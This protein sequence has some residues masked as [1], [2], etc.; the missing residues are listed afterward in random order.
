MQKMQAVR[1]WKWF[2]QC[3]EVNRQTMHLTIH[4]L[5][6]QVR[7]SDINLNLSKLDN[8]FAL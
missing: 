7:Q 6:E 3:D 8:K 1:N 2:L 5:N 4:F